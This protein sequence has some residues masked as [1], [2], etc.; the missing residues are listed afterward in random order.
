MAKLADARGLGPRGFIPWRFESSLAHQVKKVKKMAEETKKQQKQKIHIEI[1]E[2]VVTLVTTS[3]GLVAA[4]A[5]NDAVKNLFTKIFPRPEGNILA[6]F[7]Y[8]MVIS[9]IVII[10][11]LYLGR[12]LKITKEEAI[13]RKIKKPENKK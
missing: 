3:L 9:L 10:V 11:M 2:R 1:L 13:F 12:V 4:L 6:Q 7:L 8:A 5:W